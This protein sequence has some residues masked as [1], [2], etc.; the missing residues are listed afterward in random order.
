MDTTD[1]EITFDESGVCNHCRDFDSVTSKYWF[2]GENGKAKLAQ[3]VDQVK[4]DGAGKDY[5]CV[6]GLSGG[7]DS[8]YLALKVKELGLRPLVIHV[9]GG[10]NSEL[11]VKNIE[12]VVSFC[13][14]DL[15]TH[16]MNWVDMKQLQLAYLRSGVS[17]QDVP[18]DHA[19]FANLYHY[20]IEHKIKYVLS[21][22]N[23]A[24]EAIFPKAWQHGAMDATN[25]KAIFDRFGKGQ[26]QEYRTISFFQYY[27]E[28]PILRGMKVLRLLNF[29]PYNKASA[30][31]MLQE[32]TGWRPYGYK[33]GE[34]V[35]TRFYQNYYL[36][37]RFGYDKRKPHLST[38]IVTGQMSRKDALE[39]LSKS[40]YDP[41]D[42]EEDIFYFRKK[43]SLSEEE[44][45]RL[46]EIPARD[47]LEFPSDI[48]KYLLMKKTQGFV[49]RLSGRRVANYS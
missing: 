25:L 18:Q 3:I 16:V 43:L 31:E 26:L 30:I 37:E 13:N 4:K 8:S 20:A 33:H 32:K 49:T 34:S 14:F 44:F 35:F 29:M 6:L 39:E 22:G 24:T 36:V 41:S 45:Q 38:L 2:P 7:A 46:M 17:N 23:I 21:G 42:I 12:S 11:A 15:H 28:F 27:F 40:S 9:D 19:F 10:W 5:D 48:G 47:A 1:P